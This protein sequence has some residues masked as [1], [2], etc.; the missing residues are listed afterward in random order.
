MPTDYEVA[1]AQQLG[2]PFFLRT[3]ELKVTGKK[4]DGLALAYRRGIPVPALPNQGVQEV[5]LS[6]PAQQLEALG[7]TQVRRE[8]MQRAGYGLSSPRVNLF[9]TRLVVDDPP[10]IGYDEC[11]MLV[12]LLSHPS[13]DVLMVPTV[14]FAESLD[15][16][17]DE[18][19]QFNEAFVTNFLRAN[20]DTQE[21]KVAMTIPPFYGNFEPLIGRLHEAYVRGGQNPAFYTVD[22]GTQRFQNEYGRMGP[23]HR[24][25]RR[26]HKKGAYFVYGANLNPSKKS[27]DNQPAEDIV[28][29]ASGGINAIGPKRGK[30]A[31][32]KPVGDQSPLAKLPKVFSSEDFTYGKLNKGLAKPI[33]SWVNRHAPGRVDAVENLKSG[34]VHG[35]NAIQ[36]NEVLSSIVKVAAEGKPKAVEAVFGKKLALE[37]I[38]SISPMMSNTA[39]QAALV[40]S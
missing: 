6:V 16:G 30:P 23:L 25:A 36:V 39:R 34:H 8:F 33:A 37:S 32:V 26:A 2:S 11:K 21:R 28:A 3:N 1:E 10:A 22:F 7:D 15:L 27:A 31:R 13:N 38:K 19:V 35:Y 29:M 4:M 5:F 24:V 18:R 17:L 40:N 9:F 20:K 12:D 14:D